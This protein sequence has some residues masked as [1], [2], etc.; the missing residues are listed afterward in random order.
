MKVKSVVIVE[1]VF[2]S[3][4]FFLA[5]IR[6]IRFWSLYPPIDTLAGPAWREILLWLLAL[7]LM[8][9][10]LIKHDL[11]K[12]YL[13]VWRGQPFLIVF[14]LFSLA[15]IFWSTAWIV[16]LHRSLAF[17]FGTS[18]AVYL[19]IKYSMS[20]L[21][22]ILALLGSVILIASYLLIFLNPNLGTAPGFPYYGAWRGIFWH[23]NQF[24]NI[25]PI[26]TLVFMT[27]FFSYG[28][29]GNISEK[30]AVIFLYMLSLIA[31]LYSKSASG[32]ILIFILH[33][34]FAVALLWL[35][36]RHL[37]RPLHY[38]IALV[39]SLALGI[40]VLL[41]LDFVFGLVGKEA[42]LTGRIPMWGIL[43]REV[44]PLYPWFG[45]GFGTIWADLD[46]RLYMR[47]LAGWSF[48]VLIGDNGFIDI[49]LNLGIVGLVL[50]LFNYARAWIVSVKFF[51]K[52]LSLES[53]FPFIF[54]IYSLF[55][56]LTFSLFME[57]EIFIWVLIVAL[58]I[59]SIRKVGNLVPV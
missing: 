21:L 8:C 37:L 3:F 57:T 15:S 30:V 2:L 20:Q 47:D 56:N 19:G 14:V 51:L 7:F 18:M 23:K 38:Y 5:N 29:R 34:V 39:A 26:F 17:V 44:F 32:Y 22:R 31:V 16:T 25:I 52:A 43:F 1:A 13:Q 36:V 4:L 6:S 33:L 42:N 10:L 27:Y 24:G 11:L 54:M 41:N 53:F 58:T 55:A 9:Y 46:F 59:F 48:P 12:V 49:L 45:Q 50:F 35:K 40:G 28:I